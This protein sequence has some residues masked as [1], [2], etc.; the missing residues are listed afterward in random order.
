MM[1][2]MWKRPIAGGIGLAVFTVGLGIAGAWGASLGRRVLGRV[3]V[4]GTTL[5]ALEPGAW[6]PLSAGAV[7]E[8][9][10]I[11]TGA[12]GTA[13]VELPNGDL[14]GLGD[15]S[16][17]RVG[18]GSPLRVALE[19]GKLA[20]RLRRGSAMAVEIP[21][22]L[23]REARTSPTATAP[24][25][26]LVTVANDTAHVQTYRGSVEILGNGGVV[27]RVNAGQVATLD[28]AASAPTIVAAASTLSV[29]ADA[30]DKA[31]GKKKKKRGAFSLPFGLSPMWASIIAGTVVV[32][33]GVGAGLALSGG[34]SG[35]S[36]G[37]ARGQGGRGS[38]SPFRTPSD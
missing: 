2:T 3:Q 30:N 10:A 19:E 20:V 22:G 12:D 33:G 4:A 9:S 14:L 7:I 1:G 27:T 38:G 26:V 21:G 35:S 11:R 34:S 29:A 6:E 16:T 28:P 23:V 37:N 32:G 5:Q 8:G 36:G 17:L 18:T 31:G 13:V 24:H 15:Q 25:E